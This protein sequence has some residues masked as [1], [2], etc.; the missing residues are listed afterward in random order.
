[1]VPWRQTKWRRSTI[2]LLI[3]MMFFVRCWRKW[4]PLTFKFLFSFIQNLRR[5]CWVRFISKFWRKQIQEQ[6]HVSLQ[7]LENKHYFIHCVHDQLEIQLT[8]NPLTTAESAG[9][10]PLAEGGVRSSWA[11]PCSGQ[12]LV[13]LWGHQ[14][15]EGST[16]VIC[17]TNKGMLLTYT[18]YWH[19]FDTLCIFSEPSVLIIIIC[20]KLD[21]AN[22]RRWYRQNRAFLNKLQLLI[23][24]LRQ[25]SL[26]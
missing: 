14:E 17:K 13:R 18:F 11:A 5:N 16:A 26:S 6:I 21:L 4:D 20:L 2:L 25:L 10:V 9:N 22:W 23:G 1:M 24:R 7:H 8:K 12:G 3:L 19:A 15:T